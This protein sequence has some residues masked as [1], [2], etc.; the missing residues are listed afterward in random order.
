MCLCMLE[1]LDMSIKDR[2]W[3]QNCKEFISVKLQGLDAKFSQCTFYNCP[4]ILILILLF[5]CPLIF[6]F[7]PQKWHINRRKNPK[8]LS[9]IPPWFFF[10]ENHVCSLF[11]FCLHSPLSNNTSRFLFPSGKAELELWV[12]LRS[13]KGGFFYN[14]QIKTCYNEIQKSFQIVRMG[15]PSSVLCSAANA[16]QFSQNWVQHRWGWTL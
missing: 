4:S 9:L 11:A 3:L 10:P 16:Q 14:L 6:C 2:E 1:T 15:F 7:S 12:L 13:E 5:V 8:M